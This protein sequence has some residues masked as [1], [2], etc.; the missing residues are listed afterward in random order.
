MTA[1]TS[2]LL[3]AKFARQR[4]ALT[5]DRRGRRWRVLSLLLL[6]L[7]S[8]CSSRVFL[9]NRLPMLIPWYLDRYVELD[10]AQEDDLDLRIQRLLHWHRGEE[11]PRY[12]V[13][14]ERLEGSLDQPVDETVVAALTDEMEVAWYRLR[15][16]ALEEM[17]ELGETL[18]DEQIDEF[19]ASLEKTQRKYER[20]YLRRS[21]RDY[22][23]D[24]VDSM[25]DFLKDYLG[26]LDSQQSQ[27]IREMAR[28]LRRSDSTWLAE[29]EHWINMLREELRREPG[30]ADRLRRTVQDWEM[31]LD[32]E[33][34][35]LYD[36]NT[37]IVQR[38]IATIIDSRSSRQD[39][40]LRR[41]LVSLR[42]D[43][44]RLTEQ[45]REN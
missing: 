44:L 1:F 27:Q 19:I 8:A 29:R 35:E 42:E 28:Q 18:S 33:S 12:A 14:I 3:T 2:E 45:G 26:R 16:R 36:Y 22:R 25:G 39:A 32:A 34:L 20:K 37:L 6:L 7:L 4:R 38:A 5:R 17:L 30:W 9:Y 23:R 43:V 24:A 40:R 15:D 11:L 31:E 21:D 10:N 41:E 13:L